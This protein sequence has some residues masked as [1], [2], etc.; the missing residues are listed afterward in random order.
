[1]IE[2]TS[3]AFAGVIFFLFAVDRLMERLTPKSG[4]PTCYKH[5]L[6]CK[7]RPLESDVPM[8]TKI[9]NYLKL[10]EL[11]DVIVSRYVCPKGDVMIWWAPK[12]GKAEK[13]EMAVQRL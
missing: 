2:L 12:A 3:F 1:M 13:G 4:F 10:Y 11:P 6:T 9:R 8:P 7:Q 5:R